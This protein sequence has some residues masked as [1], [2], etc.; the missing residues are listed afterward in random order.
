MRLFKCKRK[1]QKGAGSYLFYL[2]T[3]DKFKNHSEHF[4]LNKL[5]EQTSF[6]HISNRM[7]MWFLPKE[8]D[9]SKW[10]WTDQPMNSDK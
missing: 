5:D 4:Q 2:V 7:I 9:A 3:K 1:G 8:R 10:V 6:R